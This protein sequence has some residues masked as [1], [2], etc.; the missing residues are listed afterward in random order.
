MNKNNKNTKILWDGSNWLTK[1]E[2]ELKNN[3]KLRKK[4]NRFWDMG[5]PK[6][7]LA[8]NRKGACK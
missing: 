7:N 1:E 8:R 2:I 6:H 5:G 3:L 4:T